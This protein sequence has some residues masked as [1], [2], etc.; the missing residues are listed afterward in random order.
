MLLDLLRT[1]EYVSF[2]KKLAHI[3][4]LESAI[5]INQVIN[6]MGKAIK[7]DK[8]VDGGYIIIDRKYIY[9]QTTLDEDKQLKL[10]EKLIKLKLIVRDVENPNQIKVDIQLLADITTND[11]VKINNDISQIVNKNV[12]VDKRAKNMLIVESM[13]RY[14]N[15]GNIDLDNKIKKWVCAIIEKFGT[16]NQSLITLFI[17]GIYAY[18]KGNLNIAFKLVDIATAYQYRECK[19]VIQ[20]YEDDLTTPTNTFNSMKVSSGVSNDEF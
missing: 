16:I 17:Q 12:K 14:I 15:T 13:S 10:E 6:I 4:G 3:I 5:Y 2:N 19:W 1:D 11:N 7:K 9:D 20:R 18:S 8:L